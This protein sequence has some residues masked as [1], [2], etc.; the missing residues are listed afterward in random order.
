MIPEA[1]EN[2]IKE[3]AM[4]KGK[5]HDNFIITSWTRIARGR[6]LGGLVAGLALLFFGGSL[7]YAQVDTGSIIGI[8]KDTSGAAISGAKVTLTSDDTGLVQTTTTGSEGEY[9]F[10]PIKIGRYSL[11]GES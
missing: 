2:Q 5:L 7:A 3:S 11:A 10:T 8:V 1:Q 4:P 9:I 6:I